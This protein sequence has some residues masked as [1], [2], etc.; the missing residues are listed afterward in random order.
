MRLPLRRVFLSHPRPW[1][2]RV[3]FLAVSAALIL[4]LVPHLP[5]RAVV[6]AADMRTAVIKRGDF[7]RTIRI[8]GSTEAVHAYV[9]QA[10]RL[11]GGGSQMVLVRLA[12]AGT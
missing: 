2:P 9:V 11:S 4:I 8:T 1:A 5:K 6:A 12:R 3:A 7:I 10:P